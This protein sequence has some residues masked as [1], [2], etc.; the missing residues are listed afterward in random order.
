[1]TPWARITIGDA[2][3]RLAA[4]RRPE[5]CTLAELQAEA[6]AYHEGSLPSL[7]ADL[8][9]RVS[10]NRLGPNRREHVKEDIAT[11]VQHLQP[12]KRNHDD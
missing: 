9:R 1:M 6:A 11:L 2:G 4:T 10:A 5:H 7:L 3:T 12:Q 8:V